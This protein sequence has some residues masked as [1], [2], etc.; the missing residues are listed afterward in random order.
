MN[1][2]DWTCHSKECEQAKAAW[3]DETPSGWGVVDGQRFCPD[4]LSPIREFL[5][6]PIRV[7]AELRR[8]TPQERAGALR[9]LCK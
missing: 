4:H 7:G 9:G 5:D 3:G 8:R 1:K 6:V 2:T